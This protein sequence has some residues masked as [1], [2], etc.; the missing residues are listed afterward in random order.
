[1]SSS[2]PSAAVTRTTMIAESPNV[3]LLLRAGSNVSLHKR[4][5]FVRPQRVDLHDHLMKTKYPPLNASARKG[6]LACAIT[7]AACTLTRLQVQ[8]LRFD[9]HVIHFSIQSNINRRNRN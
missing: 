1:M 8:R 9:L 4:I 2:S 6:L 3:D 7:A 5:N